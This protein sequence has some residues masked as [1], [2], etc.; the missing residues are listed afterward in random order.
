M[1]PALIGLLLGG[2]GVIAAVLAVGPGPS[3]AAVKRIKVTVGQNGGRKKASAEEA[4][5]LRRKQAQA[6]ALKSLAEQE[7]ESRRLRLSIKGQIA[8]AGLTISPTTFWI[9]SAGVGGVL[10]LLTLAIGGA[11]WAA[12]LALLGGALGLPRWAL[13][14]L[15]SSRHKKFQ[16]QFAD[17]IDTIVR[18]VKSGLPLNQSMQVIAAES[19]EPLR[20]EFKQLVDRQAMGVPLNQNLQRL[21][22][23]V[24]LSEVSFF[25]TVLNIQ[26]KSGGNLSEALSNLSSVL[27]SRKMLKEKVKAYSSEAKASATIIGALP[28]VVVVIV[29][30]VQPDYIGLLF[31]TEIGR[32]AL[33]GSAVMMG[34]GIFVMSKMINFKV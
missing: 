3:A 32:F 24:P 15:I 33:M 31:T 6:E 17:A 4:S 19:P 7:R 13:S 22:E 1:D 30:F 27:R 11:P 14:F 28:V 2:V 25:A 10:A 12:L 8:Q 26:Q 29:S 16:A 34:T 23:R 20:T 5:A 18:G 21:Y 9:A